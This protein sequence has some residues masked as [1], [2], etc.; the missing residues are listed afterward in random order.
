[1]SPLFAMAA[2][3]SVEPPAI[4]EA[5]SLRRRQR[6]DQLQLVLHGGR[7]LALPVEG[8]SASAHDV[9]AHD[10]VRELER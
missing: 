10:E 7:G 2:K 3:P 6:H 4:S 5:R 1:M 9:G 8:E